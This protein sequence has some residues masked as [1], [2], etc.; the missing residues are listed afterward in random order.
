MTKWQNCVMRGRSVDRILTGDKWSTLTLMVEILGRVWGE[1]TK[2]N[3]FSRGCASQTRDRLWVLECVPIAHGNNKAPHWKKKT[4]KNRIL[5]KEA[6]GDV[7]KLKIEKN[8][9]P[10]KCY[11]AERRRNVWRIIFFI[12]PV[13]LYVT[14]SVETTQNNFKAR[15]CD[16]QQFSENQTFKTIMQH[17][18]MLFESP[19][20]L[21]SLQYEQRASL[22]KENANGRW[23]LWKILRLNTLFKH[24][25]G[26]FRRKRFCYR[27]LLILQMEIH[28]NNRSIGGISWNLTKS[29][30]AEIVRREYPKEPDRKTQLKYWGEPYGG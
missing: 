2:L 28:A 21:L 13:R 12:A 14:S 8:N 22:E 17:D 23:S 1:K 26:A 10:P 15:K 6:A 9:M 25:N 30:R 11:C 24:Y 29:T 3:S 16:Q 19:L 7:L 18:R 4:Q 20:H 27:R 5:Y